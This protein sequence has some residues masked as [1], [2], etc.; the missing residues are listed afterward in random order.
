MNTIMICEQTTKRTIQQT[1][2]GYASKHNRDIC[3][4]TMHSCKLKIQSS[5]RKRDTQTE[6]ASVICEHAFCKL[7]THNPKVKSPSKLR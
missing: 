4:Q 1:Q 7:R 2:T 5:K 6:H 3:E